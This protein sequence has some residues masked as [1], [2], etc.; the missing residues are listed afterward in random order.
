MIAVDVLAVLDTHG[1]L[2]DVRTAVAELMEAAKIGRFYLA[3]VAADPF[4]V[5]K[6]AAR[7]HLQQVDAALLRCGSQP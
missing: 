4:H 1:G 7:L 5:D 2:D 6:E 3:D